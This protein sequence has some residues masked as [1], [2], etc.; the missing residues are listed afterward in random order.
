MRGVPYR[1][2]VIRY[3]RMLMW[4]LTEDARDYM[5]C[6]VIERRDKKNKLDGFHHG[7]PDWIIID[8]AVDLWWKEF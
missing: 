1:T 6:K 4:N 8:D 3:W 2:L 7:K 5:A